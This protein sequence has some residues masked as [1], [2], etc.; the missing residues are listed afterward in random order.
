MLQRVLQF[1]LIFAADEAGLQVALV[2][3]CLGGQHTAQERFLVHFQAED[4]DDGLVMHWLRSA[5]MLMASAV[6]PMEGRAAMMMSSPFCRPL[7]MRSKSVEA[8]GEAGD[9]TAL[10]VEV[11]DR[12]EGVANDDVDGLQALRKARLA[13]FEQL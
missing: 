6:L 9:F 2:D 8:R 3:A 5:A 12:A 11:V 1:P 13:D 7:V 4:G 10:L